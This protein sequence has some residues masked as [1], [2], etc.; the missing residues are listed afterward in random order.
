MPLVRR[1]D[2]LV[3]T[4]G[5]QGT[6]V[7][8]LERID[9]R[10]EVIELGP[11]DMIVFVTDGVLEARRGHRQFGRDGL[12]RALEDSDGMPPD[13]IAARIEAAALRHQGGLADDD[14]AVLVLSVPELA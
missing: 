10:D 6:L 8:L 14:I 1:R 4:V 3:E 2:G 11:G 12:A 7:G 9:V 5:V 13:A